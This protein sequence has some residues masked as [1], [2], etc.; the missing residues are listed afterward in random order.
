MENRTPTATDSHLYG[1]PGPLPPFIGSKYFVA[2]EYILQAVASA[3]FLP[4][5]SQSPGHDRLSEHDCRSLS[6]PLGLP[7]HLV[8]LCPW[9][10]KA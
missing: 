9:V 10:E 7:E 3:E 1:P 8:L 5:D 4:L 6:S 2:L